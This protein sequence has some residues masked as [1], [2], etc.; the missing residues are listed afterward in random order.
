MIIDAHTHINCDELY[1]ERKEIIQ[2]AIDNKV[3]AVFNTADSLNSFKNIDIL[4]KEYSNYCYGVYG[5]HPEFASSTNFT[6]VEEEIIKRK[7]IIKAIG[8][9]GLDYHYPINETEKNNQKDIFISQICLAKKLNLPIVIHSR[10]ADK[11]TFDI[12]CQYAQDMK[13]YLH[14]YSGSYEMAKEYI[15]KIPNI[16]FGVGGIVTFKNAKKLVEVVEKIDLK[17]FLTETD[18][19][20]LTPVPFRGKQNEPSYLIYVINK[21]S[22]LKN[23]N[24]V[25]VEEILF[26]NAREFFDL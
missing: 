17:Y 5:I 9:I 3:M 12:L 19:P 11:D 21:I 4:Q 13:V 24:E 14:C 8:E 18:A 1:Q 7:N 2:R 15:K 20:Y 26:E 23:M 6:E 10:D 16:H 25:K 22:E